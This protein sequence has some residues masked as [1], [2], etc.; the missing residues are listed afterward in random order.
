[1]RLRGR[2]SRKFDV[3]KMMAVGAYE[4]ARFGAAHTPKHAAAG[5]SAAEWEL[6]T[7]REPWGPTEGKNVRSILAEAVNVSLTMAGLPAVP[8]PAEYVAAVIYVLVAP[9]NRMVAASRAPEAYDAVKASGLAAPVEIE[10][11]RQETMMSLVQAYSSGYLTDPG[12]G[13]QIVAD[14]EAAL[15][16][17]QDK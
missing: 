7:S 6:L 4:L 11:V 12:T 9:V 3:A 17:Q 14:Q 16:D 15:R 5:F 10:A 13:R 1:M 8:M 2:R